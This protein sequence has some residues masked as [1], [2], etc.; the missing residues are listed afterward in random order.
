MLRDLTLEIESGAIVGVAGPN[1]SGKTTLLRLVATLTQ[2]DQGSGEVLGARLGSPDVF[3]IRNRIGLI[4]HTPSLIPELTLEENLEHAL[5]LAGI[6]SERA[7]PALRAV[8]LEGA[9]A[10]LASDASFGMRRRAE[11]ARLLVTG[12]DLLLLDEALSGL[13]ADAQ[14]L[15]KALVDRTLQRSGA[16]LLVSHDASTMEDL[17]HRV[18]TI[19]SGKLL[20]P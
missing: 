2:P 9:R 10:R 6:D 15:I 4:S 11:V 5:R 16:A 7:L 13:D 18:F 19:A 3:M 8:G 17:A 14:H 12:P 20:A 1:G